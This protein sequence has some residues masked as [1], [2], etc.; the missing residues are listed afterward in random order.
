MLK[1][2]NLRNTIVTWDSLNTRLG[3][4]VAV[5]DAD[6]DFVVG[7]KSNQSLL[8]ED[9]ITAFEYVDKDGYRYEVLTAS[10]VSEYHGR[11]ETKKIDIIEIKH[12]IRSELKKKIADVYSINRE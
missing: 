6:A 5:V 11:I 7:L 2:V 1:K 12:D 10:R 3:T 8:E 4:V 9:A